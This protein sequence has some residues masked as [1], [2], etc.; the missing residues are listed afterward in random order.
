MSLTDQA[1]VDMKNIRI[2]ATVNAAHADKWLAGSGHTIAE[3]LKLADAG[4]ALPR[5]PLNASL[6]AKVKVE[7]R[8]VD[9]RT[10]CRSPEDV[11]KDEYVVLSAHLD[12]VG[13][14][15]DQGRRDLQRP[16]TT[17]RAWPRCSDRARPA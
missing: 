17:P 16:W 6:R 2:A 14:G 12:H 11:L 15:A 4:Q 13:V 10:C 5:F 9:R 1:L 7:R 3:L 8:Q